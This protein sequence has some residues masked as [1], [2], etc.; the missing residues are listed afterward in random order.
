MPACGAVP[1]AASWQA[2]RKIMDHGYGLMCPAYAAI[3]G[4]KFN[5]H[6]DAFMADKNMQEDLGKVIEEL[7]KKRAEKPDSITVHHQLGLVYRKA[8]RIE[9]ALAA[10]EKAIDLDPFSVESL[11]NLG[12]LYFD[13]GNMD[14]AQEVNERALSINSAS[15]QANA[16]LGLIWQNRMDAARA[17]EYYENAVKHEPKLVTV[18]I[19]MTSVHLMAGNDAK[20]LDAAR[21]AVKL[22][23][24]FPMAQN[25]LAVALYYN[26]RYQ[27]AKTH[28]DKAAALG[29]AVDGRFL[30]A[31]NREIS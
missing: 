20:A 22:E 23:P 14:K 13:A 27:E 5:I 1:P 11:V 10:L 28:A 25:N 24:D 4:R 7:E 12:G 18:W 6:E 2:T 26:K 31:L 21:E 15:A 17:L 9:E 30:D 19:N 16:N 8:G 3:P 29:Y